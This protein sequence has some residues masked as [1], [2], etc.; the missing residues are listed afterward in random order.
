MEERN[1]MY[2]D[3]EMFDAICTQCKKPCKVPFKP[4]EGKVVYCQ[5][6]FRERIPKRSRF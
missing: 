2:E 3:R 4:T 5:D 6:C 1:N